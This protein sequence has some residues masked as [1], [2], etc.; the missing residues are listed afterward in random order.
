MTALFEFKGTV[1]PNRFPKR[2][3][4]GFSHPVALPT[5]RCGDGWTVHLKAGTFL[6]PDAIGVRQNPRLREPRRFEIQ[7]A[8]WM[9]LGTVADER[10]D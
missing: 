5:P 1:P 9:V 3:K 4:F 7:D 6:S 10:H 2:K 8:R